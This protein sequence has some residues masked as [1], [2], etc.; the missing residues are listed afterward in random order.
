M[1]TWEGR[2]EKRL[3][4]LIY[5]QDATN[6]TISGRGVLAA[7]LQGWLK[8]FRRK[9]SRPHFIQFNRC[10]D[11][12]LRDFRITGSPAW[13]IHLYQ[14][15][16]CRIE[17]LD[18][19]ALGHNND[20]VDIEMSRDV[21]I[22]NCRFDQGDDGICL[23]SGRDEEGRR[24]GIPT[25]NVVVRNCR[26]GHCHGMLAIGS[27]LSGGIRNVRFSD[28]SVENCGAMVRI[29]TTPSRGGFVE[30]IIVRNCRGGEMHRVFDIMT[31]YSCNPG[32]LSKGI[33]HTPIRSVLIDGIDAGSCEY[34]YRLHCDK[35][36]PPE[37]V[38][39]RNVRIGKRRLP[40]DEIFHFFP[41]NTIQK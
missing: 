18:C 17:G 5:A 13:M 38:V 3:S 4:P 25:E 30:D 11:V 39:V 22:E 7:R 31:N 26:F 23:K 2:T 15:A 10:R 16:G 27:E 6:V 34:A 33:F 37:N 9:E 28:C 29:K 19:C 36:C 24:I 14:T 1:T 40:T 12:R 8:R 21:V 32:D 35:D 20:G 41:G